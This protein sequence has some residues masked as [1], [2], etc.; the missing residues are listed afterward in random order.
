MSFFVSKEISLEKQSEGIAVSSFDYLSVEA[1]KLISFLQSG[2]FQS[3]SCTFDQFKGFLSFPF[4]QTSGICASQPKYWVRISFLNTSL[5]CQST[6]LSS[7]LIKYPKVFIR[8]PIKSNSS[9]CNGFKVTSRSS[10]PLI[11]F[12]LNSVNENIFGGS[13]KRISQKLNLIQPFLST[14]L[15]F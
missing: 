1:L 2:N 10:A 8:L 4:L 3:Q 6:I 7:L 13:L 14:M 15:P 11:Q 5:P 9:L 12:K